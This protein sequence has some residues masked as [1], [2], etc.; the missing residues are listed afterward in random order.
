VNIIVSNRSA[1]EYLFAKSVCL[2]TGKHDCLFSASGVRNISLIGYGATW[3]M[4]KMDYQN[5]TASIKNYSKAEWRHGLQLHDT[6]GITV[7][8]LTIRQTGGDGIDMGGVISGTVN[9]HVYDCNL[10]DNHR[11]G[12][13][14]GVAKNLLVQRVLFANTSGT[15]PQSGVDL[16]PDDA[17][18][19]LV[20]VSFIDC[21]SRFNAGNQ[22]SISLFQLRDTSEP[23]SIRFENVSIEGS[24]RE[25]YAGIF[26]GGVQPGVKGSVQIQNVRVVRT[27]G[28]G[29]YLGDLAEPALF[30]VRFSNTSFAHVA[31]QTKTKAALDIMHGTNT[32]FLRAKT[33]GGVFFDEHCM[34][35]NECA[36]PFFLIED[37]S[38]QEPGITA[39]NISYSGIVHVPAAADCQPAIVA[40]GAKVE[41]NVR[42][43]CKVATHTP[44]TVNIY[45]L[46]AHPAPNL[47]GTNFHY[48]G[49][50]GQG[51]PAEMQGFTNLAFAD[52]ASQA[53]EQRRHGIH[54]LVKSHKFCLN[55]TTRWH[56]TLLPDCRERLAAVSLTFL[57][58]LQNG[59]VL[60]FFLGDELLWNGLTFS[61]LQAYVQLMRAA[62]PPPAILYYNEAWP[63]LLPTPAGIAQYVGDIGHLPDK[64]L[65][66][67]VPRE[68]DWFSVDI[69][70]NLSSPLFTCVVTTV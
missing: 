59:T 60:G 18:E 67:F 40:V 28:P 16:E 6:Y 22:I 64:Q 17:S 43:V 52:N 30:S 61:S 29:A 20:N 46:G 33:M 41:V 4:H 45:G 55:Y 68:L 15:A 27:N 26:V 38:G 32:A 42:P 50:W 51:P 25:G 13:S 14:V 44:D 10:V 53:L 34:V 37:Q 36:R 70:R 57:P 2:E 69:V 11:Q 31:G 66:Q 65:L 54:A 12:M 3:R 35:V 9:T 19:W 24:P 48:L 63:S 56:L 1:V 49:F 23:T 62:F 8:G 21:V 39:V 47:T 5:K 7:A 58:L